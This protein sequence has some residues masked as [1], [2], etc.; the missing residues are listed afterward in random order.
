MRRWSQL[1]LARQTQASAAQMWHAGTPRDVQPTWLVRRR[2]RPYHSSWTGWRLAAYSPHSS[3][4][5]L[6]L[7]MLLRFA[8]CRLGQRL[9][10][11]QRVLRESSPSTY[12][13]RHADG[14]RR[15]GAGLGWWCRGIL[16]LRVWEDGA[17]VLLDYKTNRILPEGPQAL[18]G[19]YGSWICTAM[20]PDVTSAPVRNAIQPAVQWGA[21]PV[22]PGA[23]W[24]VGDKGKAF[25]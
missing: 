10:R 20:C 25:G 24:D 2:A 16:D 11:A 15:A 3:A 6:P 5:A 12:R 8:R 13:C 9:P 17:W 22:A 23:V 14:S 1:P 19:A 4:R 18:V 7:S 21:L